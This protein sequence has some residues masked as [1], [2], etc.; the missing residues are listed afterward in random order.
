MTGSFTTL[1]DPTEESL[2]SSHFLGSS[3]RS[4]SSPRKVKSETSKAYKQAE[5]FFVTRRFPEALASIEPLITVPH[6]Q[7]D[8]VDNE[9]TRDVAPIAKASP[10]SRIK[11]WSFYLTLLNAIAELGPEDG[12]KDFGSREWKNI[13]AKAQEGTI[14]DEVVNIGY[15]GIEGNID[16]EVV[17]NL[18]SLLL[19]QSPT[20]ARNQQHLE[21]YLSASSYPSLDLTDRLQGLD[22]SQ[23]LSVG[24]TSRIGGTDTPRDLNARVRI[25]ELFTLHILPR[26]GE[27]D[28]ARTFIKMS[29]ILDEE[30]RDDFL[31][32]LQ[33]LKD[34]DSKGQ[35][36]FE[37][38]L[39]QPDELTAQEPLPFEETR[40]DSMETVRQQPLAAPDRS[41][42]EQDYGVDK[43]VAP[44]DNP[45]ERSAPPKAPQNPAKAVQSRR[46]RSTPTKST[47]KATK[48]SIFKR[49]AAV[50]SALQQL[51]KNMTEQMSQ[52]RMSLLRFVLFLMGLII[53]FS[54]RDVKDRLGRLTGAGWDKVKRTVGMGVKVSYI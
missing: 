54:R 36:P 12:K 5:A 32:T 11:V 24:Q 10:R 6:S 28:Y 17:F 14:W 3:V 1:I 13:V 51:I 34:E 7:S 22:G 49:S 52:N 47:G 42:S 27:W 23:N 46:S 44:P 8:T 45:K 29:E 20:Q 21:S 31:Q 25:I 53:A 50:L 26:T 40:S 33:H 43:P 9:A 19:A 39:P 2:S 37:E 15:G 35:G 18:A 30:I 48:S 4:I 41:N 38:D 16:A